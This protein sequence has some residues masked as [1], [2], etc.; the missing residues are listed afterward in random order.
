MG[1]DLPDD[2]KGRADG[3]ALGAGMLM[4]L[5]QELTRQARG[6]TPVCLFGLV[7][8]MDDH[9]CFMCFVRDVND[10]R[11]SY[12]DTGLQMDDITLDNAAH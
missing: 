12:L 6:Q 5:M 8:R 2:G 4:A 3:K 7:C 1:G 11:P 9:A 10:G